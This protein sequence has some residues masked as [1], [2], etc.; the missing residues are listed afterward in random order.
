MTDSCYPIW[1]RLY[2][3]HG[4]GSYQ[5]S[6]NALLR[7]LIEM[8]KVPGRPMDYIIIDALDESPDNSGLLSER[9]KVLVGLHLPD[10]HICVSSRLEA[11]IQAALTPLV[12]LCVSLHD[13]SEQ[14]GDITS[15]INTVV[16]SDQRM[17]L[18]TVDDKN[19]SEV[20]LDKCI[21]SILED[22]PEKLN[23]TYEPALLGIH[24]VKQEFAQ[25]LFQ[26]LAVSARPLHAEELAE[27]LAVW[28]NTEVPPE[29][30][31]GWR[32][33]NAE[34]AVLSVGSSLVAIVSVDGCRVVQFS[35]FSVKE[36]LMSHCLATAREDLSYYHITPHQIQDLPLA[37]Y[38]SRHWFGHCR[39]FAEDVPPTI[40][41]AAMRLFDRRKPHFF[42]R[43]WM[44]DIDSDDPSG[45]SMSTEHPER[46]KATP[47]YYAL[48]SGLPWLVEDLITQKISTPEKGIIRLHCLPR[49][50]RKTSKLLCHFCSLAPMRMPWTMEA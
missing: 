29:F 38:A 48:L 3:S 47:L 46:P 8:L 31:K 19:F 25:R 23:G 15:Y 35:H 33:G 40:R 20:L 11:D 26:C 41:D 16:H 37:D 1:S 21:Q 7:C 42:A 14:K 49:S 28:F 39:Q 4:K 24:E 22:F 45:K 9:E 34:D 10:M 18:W 44:Y 32:P 13:E 43:V 12:P 17:Q 6:K 30:N 36:F 5:P 50:P 2:S 27:V